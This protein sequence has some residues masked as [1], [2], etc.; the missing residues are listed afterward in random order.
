MR[1]WVAAHLT[2]FTNQKWSGM[3]R[4]WSDVVPFEIAVYLGI[5]VQRAAKI[6]AATKNCLLC[7]SENYFENETSCA[8]PMKHQLANNCLEIGQ[9]T[10]HCVK[11]VVFVTDDLLCGRELQR[12]RTDILP[13][14]SECKTRGRGRI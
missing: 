6:N 2:V 11:S 12:F 7:T 5:N 14:S 13:L 9:N 10:V 3:P 8:R 1:V 4:E